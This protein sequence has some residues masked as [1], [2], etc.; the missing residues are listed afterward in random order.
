ME[1]DLALVPFVDAAGARALGAGVAA[2]DRAYV[3]AA[4]VRAQPAV[5]LTG[6]G[7]DR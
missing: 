4:I 6:S 7:L 1:I 3:R 2:A 5:P